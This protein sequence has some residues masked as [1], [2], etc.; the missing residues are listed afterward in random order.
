MFLVRGKVVT[1]LKVIDKGEILI[2]KDKIVKI[3]KIKES[4]SSVKVFN[5]PE[6]VVVAGFIDIHMHGL[7][8]HGPK[9]K[10]NII[11]MSCLESRYGTTGFIPTLAS[12]THKEYLQFLQ[13]VKEAIKAQPGKG[14][15]VLGAH[16]E[17]PYI[18]RA[19]KGGMDE[20]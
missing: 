10:K 7:G 12:A 3:G 8:K 19:M 14:A 1:P 18:N 16:L 11:G 6:S 17:G 5:I 13:D 9:G 15:K 2:D 4:F 20:K